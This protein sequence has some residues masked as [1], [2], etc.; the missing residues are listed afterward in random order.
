MRVR[1][2]EPPEGAGQ[3][4]LGI[5]VVGGEPV[6]RGPEVVVVGFEAL[7]ALGFSLHATV[8]TL[9]GQGAKCVCVAAA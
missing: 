6:E 3:L 2:P 5:R 4:E 1:K 7:R 9:S 8:V